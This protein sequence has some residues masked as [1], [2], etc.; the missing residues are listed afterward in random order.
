[1]GAYEFRNFSPVPDPAPGLATGF[2]GTFPNPTRTDEST[3]FR[4][5]LAAVESVKLSVYDVT[6]REV[7]TLIDSAR[8]GQGEHS[9][10]W[11]GCDGNGESVP[12]GAYCC[13][14]ELLD[15]RDNTVFTNIALSIG[16]QIKYS[17]IGGRHSHTTAKR[18]FDLLSRAKV[19]RQIPSVAP[20]RSSLSGR[21]C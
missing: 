19:I 4:F 9:Y 6:G 16:Q 21:S 18:A 10:R 2:I 15:S 3:I 13:R 14:L 7:R 5:R 17:R 8:L 12:A 20:W 11:N 1:M